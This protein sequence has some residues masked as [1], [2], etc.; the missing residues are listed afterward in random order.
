MYGGKIKEIEEPRNAAVASYM[1][2]DVKTAMD[3]AK[4]F[5][6]EIGGY[7]LPRARA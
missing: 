4:E 5:F 6:D 3:K 2:E 7:P 1:G